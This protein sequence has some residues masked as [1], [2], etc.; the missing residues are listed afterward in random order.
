MGGGGNLLKFVDVVSEKGCESQGCGNKDWNSYI[1]LIELPESIKN[2]ICFD[3]I[4]LN[5][6]KLSWKDSYHS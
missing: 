3:V 2:A 5:I 6:S 4:Q 1:Y